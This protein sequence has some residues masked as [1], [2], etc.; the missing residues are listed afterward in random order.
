MYSLYSLLTLRRL[1]RRLAVLPLPGDPLPEVHRQPAAA[2]RLPADHASTSTARSRSGFTPCR[3]AKRSPPAR[4]SPTSGAAIRAC[5]CSC[6]RRR[7]RGSRWRGGAC[8]TSTRCSTFRSTGPSSSGA[9]SRLVKPRLFIMMETEIW[10]N[11][12][13]DCRRARRQDG[14]DQRPHLVAFVPALPA[15]PAVLPPRARR[16]RSLLHAER[17]IGAAADRSRRRPG[18]ASRSPAA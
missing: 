15:D 16:R 4:S 13:R 2:P 14:D 5:A 6:R 7:S 1:R 17:G 11:L 3:S 8:S 10:P 9:R 18:P 12:L